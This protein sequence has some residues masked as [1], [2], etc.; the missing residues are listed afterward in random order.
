MRKDFDP[1]TIEP[2]GR[3][4]AKA[5]LF[6][7]QADGPW[8][9]NVEGETL[10]ARCTLLA[11]GNDTPGEGPRLGEGVRAA[12]AASFTWRASASVPTATMS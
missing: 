12:S 10:N 11:Y 7:P 8:R 3:S 9:G 4:A 2:D 1:A 5:R 6:D